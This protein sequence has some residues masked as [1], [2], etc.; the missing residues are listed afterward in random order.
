MKRKLISLAVI[1]ALAS[2]P[3]LA[4][5]DKRQET[6]FKNIGIVAGG[7]LGAIVG[8][9]P[10]AIAGM[11]VGGITTDREL[12]QQRK[13]ALEDSVAEFGRERDSLRSD[14]RSQKARIAELVHRL[15]EQESLAANRLDAGLLAHSL[16]LEVGFRTDSAALP[17]GAGEA[18]DALAGLLQAAPGLEVRLDGYADPRGA[19]A[20][21]LELSAKR[22]A[23]VR[24]RL[25]AA[26]IAPERIHLSAHGAVEA[27]A[28]DA[29]ADP[30]GW[31]LQR[32]VSIRL[33]AAEGRLAARP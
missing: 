14:H 5:P 7:V 26:G 31:A 32:R 27:L 4:D 9:P 8:G 13:L 15:E 2:A 28:P 21:N 12:I 25:V 20:H 24:E 33:E 23:A 3:A 30:D 16:E 29:S 6:R 18:I 11:A 10:G 17:D 19:T 22:A 1:A